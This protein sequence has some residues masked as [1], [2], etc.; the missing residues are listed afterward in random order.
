MVVD[1]LNIFLQG[2][3]KYGISKHMT[4]TFIKVLCVLHSSKLLPVNPLCYTVFAVHGGLILLILQEASC[5]A[6][7]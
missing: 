2:V 5:F 6:K 4:L 1:L 3:S 7:V